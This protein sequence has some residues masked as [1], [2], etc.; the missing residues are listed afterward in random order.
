MEANFTTHINNIHAKYIDLTNL[1]TLCNKNSLIAHI[2]VRSL[3]K[4]GD[5]LILTLQE[6]NY[7][8]EFI[9]ISEAW[10]NF[11]NFDLQGFN[12][13]TNLRKDKRGGGVAI[14]AKNNIKTKIIKEC[15]FSN[16][17]T[18]ILTLQYKLDGKIKLIA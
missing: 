18:E 4:N 11:N 12:L 7:N 13:N 2:N 5:K 10:G 3:D 6:L 8:M 1:N 9:C 16:E 14:L 15:T 17:N